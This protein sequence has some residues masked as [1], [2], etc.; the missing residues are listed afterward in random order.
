MS[1]IGRGHILVVDD[2]ENWREA[3]RIL[4]ETEG[5]LV[6]ESSSFE[7]AECMLNESVFDMV[8]LDVR[9]VDE[10]VFNVEGLALLHAVRHD[11]PGARV[12]FVTGYPQSVGEESGADALIFKVPQGS[13]FDSAGFTRLVRDLIG[14][15]AVVQQAG[16]SKN[17]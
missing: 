13:T 6:S 17:G 8:V 9:L 11:C 2:Q 10:D 14:T 3:L 16:E 5:F 12:V 1:S 4:L 15:G 7:Q